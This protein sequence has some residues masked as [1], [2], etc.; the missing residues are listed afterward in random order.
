MSAL[1]LEASVRFA[2][3][4]QRADMPGH[5]HSADVFALP[6]FE[7]GMPNVVLEAMASGLPVV[8]TDIYGNRELVAHEENGLLF[9]P[10][11]V[12]AL[13]AALLRLA[14]E[15]EARR[16]MGD[17]SRARAQDY[18]WGRTAQTYWEL[19]QRVIA[20]RR[21]G[22]VTAGRLMRVLSAVGRRPALRAA[23][24][25]LFSLALLTWLFTRI[26]VAQLWE[27]LLATD[28]TLWA[29]GLATAVAAWLLNTA[30]WRV[31][32]RALGYPSPYLKL[33]GLNF[34][35]M[36]YSIVLPGQVS[37]EVVK[38]FRLARQG[39]PSGPT[40]MT[41]TLD[42]LTGLVALGLLGLVGAAPR[43]AALPQRTV[44]RPL[45][46]GCAG[47]RQP[48]CAAGPASLPAPVTASSQRPQP[49]ATLSLSGPGGHC[50]LPP[51]APSAGISSGPSAWLPGAGRG[52]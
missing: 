8:T 20:R 51:V 22:H 44:P 13:E 32:L 52:I 16:G 41:I 6:S 50:H 30:K 45:R 7:E 11:S 3:W 28:F 24:Q 17:R 26:D 4:A 43:A 2:G 27:A 33:L 42:R 1:G 48:Y 39:V 25:A 34:I 36:F 23:A 37:G 35:G 14:R 38:G 10:A 47:R 15:P 29:A 46:A 18:G 31:L 21:E 5:Y 40:T 9:P 19:S 12:Q 49:A